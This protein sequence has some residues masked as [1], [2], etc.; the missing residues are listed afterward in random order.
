MGAAVAASKLPLRR[1]VRTSLESARCARLVISAKTAAN[2]AS[3]VS[4][5]ATTKYPVSRGNAPHAIPN[6]RSV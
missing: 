1:I 6:Q 3:T 5:S 4:S 2:P